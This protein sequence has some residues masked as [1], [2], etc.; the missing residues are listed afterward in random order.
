MT[1]FVLAI[2]LGYFQ[3]MFA[4]AIGFF[5]NLFRKDYATAI[6]NHLVWLIFLNSLLVFGVSKAGVWSANVGTIAGWIA[7]V[8][9]VLIF[10]FTERKSGFAGRLGG[11]VF[12]LFSTVFY[13]GDVLSYV[14]LMALGMV[15][16][17]LGMAVN[18]LVKLVME[19][20]YVGFILGA[21]LFV[22]GHL[23]NIV[24]SV[25]SSF[26][27]SLRLQFVEFF[28]KFFTGGGQEFKPL[29]LAYKYTMPKSE[30]S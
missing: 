4:L 19:V 17:G 5:N 21:V 10:W 25:L 15:T 7:V 3:I 23:L 22:G 1:F 11:G 2:G 24:L 13:F 30:N 9:A 20:P 27:H 16:A 8:Q 28:P 18:I 12:A 29:S 6:F 14:R 26:V